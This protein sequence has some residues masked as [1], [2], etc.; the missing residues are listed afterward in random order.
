MKSAETKP[1]NL[2]AGTAAAAAAT[3]AGVAPGRAG[4]AAAGACGGKNGEL[5]GG[6]FAGTLGTGDFLLL[7]DNNFFE[8]LV[9][10]VANVFVDGHGEFLRVLVQE[11]L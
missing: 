9:A 2:V 6:F 8:A 4:R 11:R 3:A 7:V 1:I 5:D 10:G